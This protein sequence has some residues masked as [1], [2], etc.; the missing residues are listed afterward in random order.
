MAV[1]GAARRGGAQEV[2]ELMKAG[3]DTEVKD[4]NGYTALHWAAGEG[5]DG[6]VKVLLEAG[7]DKEAKDK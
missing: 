1:H 4:E 5:Q 3:A 6:A 2:K 7:A